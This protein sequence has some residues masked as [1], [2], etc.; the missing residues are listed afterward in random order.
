MEG[1]ALTN[2]ELSSLFTCSV[3]VAQGVPALSDELLYADER[4]Y[5]A[6]S[7]PKRRAEFGTAR[8]LSRRALAELGF[9]S[10]SLAPNADRSP[11]WPPGA[12]GT[13][14]HTRGYCAVAVAP[15]TSARGLG[16]DVERARA[17][18][19]ALEA[20]VCTENEQLWLDRQ[21]YAERGH[22]AM[23]IFSAKESFYKSQYPIT[24]RFLG[25]LDVELQLDLATNTFSVAHLRRD[26][27]IWEGV[28]RARGRFRRTTEF[29]FTAATL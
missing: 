19:T 16:L 13:I 26:E 10:C 28:R 14:T 12:I 29:I 11:R 5:I 23:L 2:T 18:S 21:P 3:V 24:G 22:L 6:D 27:P 8:V 9:P 1:I 15:S 20:S 4:D 25:F 17:L 7:V